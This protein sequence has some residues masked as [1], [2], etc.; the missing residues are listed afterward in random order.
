MKKFVKA[1][2]ALILAG[3]MLLTLAG[4]GDKSASIKK[5]FEKEGFTVTTVDTS[6]STVKG[7]L[8]ILLSQ[9]QMEKAAEYEIILCTKEGILNA[10]A[11]AAIIKFPSAKELQNFLTVEKSDGTKDTTAYDKALENGTVNGNCMIFT[12]SSSSNDIFKKA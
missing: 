12:A 6:N 4:C 9:E 2:T 8:S 10:G 7:L 5:A 3:I 1:L 11:T